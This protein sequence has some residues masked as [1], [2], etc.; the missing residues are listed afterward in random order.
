MR[1]LPRWGEK[2]NQFS[3]VIKN[4]L[5]NRERLRHFFVATKNE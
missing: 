4:I 2:Q 1:L 5:Q 3:I